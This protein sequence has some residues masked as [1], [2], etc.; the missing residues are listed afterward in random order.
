MTTVYPSCVFLF[1]ASATISLCSVYA[2]LD[3]Q[4]TAMRT[5]AHWEG[6]LNPIDLHAGFSVDSSITYSLAGLSIGIVHQ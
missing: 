1:F 4:R 2:A 5:T 3:M 6:A